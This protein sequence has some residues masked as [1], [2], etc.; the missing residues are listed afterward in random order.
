VTSAGIELRGVCKSY[1]GRRVLSD[2]ALRIAP[3]EHLAVL[4]P[5]GC[6]K[7]TLL[8]LVAGLEEPTGGEILL[9]GQPASQPQRVLV[10]PHRRGIAMVFQDLAL[11]PNL[12]AAGN[13]R[14]GLAGAGLARRAVE[15]QVQ[16]VLALCGIEPL[17]RRKPG[18]LS[19]GEQQRVA[20]ARALAVR[21]RFL[22]LDE[23]FAGID[24][25]TKGRLLE[26]IARL[27]AAQR[28]TVVLVTH[29]PFEAAALCRSAAVLEA[30][31]CVE[32][33]A[34]SSLL[35]SPTST[36]LRQFRTQLRT[37][38]AVQ[39]GPSTSEAEAPG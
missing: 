2:V 31:Q 26:E 12:T 13:V 18:Q 25:V 5:S 4:G 22:L 29:D 17:A 24:L 32:Q 30:G 19:G 15:E 20:L 21:P 8:R 36:I 37:V 6:G 33:G 34:L 38:A 9:D 28:A 3:G 39:D 27:A 16:S 1:A 35:A 10:P 7:S 23:P 11:W 14:L